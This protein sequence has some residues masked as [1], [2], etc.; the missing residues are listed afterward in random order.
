MW[1]ASFLNRDCEGLRK[2]VGASVRFSAASACWGN[3]ALWRGSG[4]ARSLRAQ[5]A[6]GGFH[7]VLRPHRFTSG[8]LPLARRYPRCAARSRSTAAEEN[9]G[10]IGRVRAEGAQPS[11]RPTDAAQSHG[12]PTVKPARSKRLACGA[13]PTSSR[14][15]TLTALPPCSTG[16]GG[17]YP[18]PSLAAPAWRGAIPKY[19]AP[20][21]RSRRSLTHGTPA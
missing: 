16:P 11:S 18:G 15:R 8:A 1:V 4:A 19:P 14:E 21:A 10:A 5:L 17:F 13:G 7:A 9:R 12:A 20:L 3:S 6:G 2:H